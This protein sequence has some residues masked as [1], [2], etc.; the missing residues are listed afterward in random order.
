MVDLFL[1]HKAPQAEVA[2]ERRVHPRTRAGGGARRL[3][4]RSADEPDG[5]RGRS[6]RSERSPLR[7]NFR[8]RRF[9]QMNN[10]TNFDVMNKI[11]AYL[12]YQSHRMQ[13]LLL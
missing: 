12:Y 11:Y 2:S 9:T 7:G 3:A 13:N 4:V 5:G 10:C 6:E 8:L 1:C